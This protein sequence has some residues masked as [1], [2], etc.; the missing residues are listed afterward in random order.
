MYIITQDHELFVK[1]NGSTV[2]VN[3]EK[4]VGLT[5]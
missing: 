3:N 2:L 4:G 1:N 5:I